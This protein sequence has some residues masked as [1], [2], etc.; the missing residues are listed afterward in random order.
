MN[1]NYELTTPRAN[2][3]FDLHKYSPFNTS[4]PSDDP[5]EMGDKLIKVNLGTG[6]VA[7]DMALGE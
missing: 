5:T 6:E 3:R 2:H 7:V 1:Y 4:S